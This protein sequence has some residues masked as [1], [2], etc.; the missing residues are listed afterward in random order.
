MKHLVRLFC[1]SLMGH[2]LGQRE[3][4][5]S[6]ISHHLGMLDGGPQVNQGLTAILLRLIRLTDQPL[7]VSTRLLLLHPQQ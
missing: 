6:T 2:K 5:P 4:V 7:H 3:F 1:V